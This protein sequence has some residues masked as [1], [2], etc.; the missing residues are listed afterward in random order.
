LTAPECPKC[1]HVYEVKQ[2]K[3]MEQVDGKLEKVTAERAEEARKRR[4]ARLAQ[5]KAQTVD[6]IEA[7]LRRQKKPNA[8]KTA[9]KIF[10]ARQDKSDLVGAIVDNFEAVREITEQPSFKTFGVTLSAVRNMK[11]KDLKALLARTIDER[12]RVEAASGQDNKPML[13]IQRVA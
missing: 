9:E 13:N 8:R 7:E 6:E 1:G 2:R 10:Q 5:G 4:A 12:A 11:P 3:E